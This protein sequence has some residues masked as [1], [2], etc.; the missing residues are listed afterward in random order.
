MGVSTFDFEL[1]LAN[2]TH[3]NYNNFAG[4]S[5]LDKTFDVPISEVVMTDSQTGYIGI[6]SLRTSD[7]HGVPSEEQVITFENFA[8]T[9]PL[10]SPFV[11]NSSSY[12]SVGRAPITAPQTYQI[13][14]YFQGNSSF[15]GVATTPA[16]YNV[17][18]RDPNQGTAG[19]TATYRA[20]FLQLIT[21]L[22]N[23]QTYA[24]TLIPEPPLGLL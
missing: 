21:N 20:D 15:D 4:G 17:L 9:S 2:G 23:F 24:P 19:D 10:T 16:S 18:A 1:V 3:L 7:F 6:G 22:Q 13:Q 8:P 11:V 14:A 5:T 12:Y